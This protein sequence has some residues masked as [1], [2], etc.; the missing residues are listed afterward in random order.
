MDVDIRHFSIW[1]AHCDELTIEQAIQRGEDEINWPKLDFVP[2]MQRRRLSPFA[3]MALLVANKAT[4]SMN[5]EL[6]IVFSSRHGDLPKTSTL[7]A[8]LAAKD[9]LSP[10]AFGLSVHNAIPSLFSILTNNK[11]A[12]NAISAGQ[13]SF[14][15]G[16]IDVY[17]RLKSGLAEEILFIYA[18]QS[19]PKTYLGFQ[20][21]QQLSHA[22]AMVVSLPSNEKTA[23]D[24]RQISFQFEHFLQ[25]VTDNV[26]ASLLFAKWYN[27]QQQKI[28]LT[29]NHYQ[30]FLSQDV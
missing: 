30:W 25:A 12:I 4:S 11:Q 13:D 20:D 18:D 22:I 24:K 14:M 17:S 29:S 16:L 10:T 23:D 1:H 5:I 8:D 21:E 7:L 3:K 15:M 27:S 26:P 2:A 19:L 28:A 6:P 9:A